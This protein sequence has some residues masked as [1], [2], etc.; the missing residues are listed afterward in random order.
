[1]PQLDKFIFFNQYL[2][3]TIF[4]IIL[5]CL[6][7]FIIL[8]LVF[9]ILKIRKKKLVLLQTSLNFFE[10]ANNNFKSSIISF[11][12]SNIL[13]YFKIQIDLLNNFYLVQFLSK[14][15]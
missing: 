9:K 6:F 5:Y 13:N 11:Y 12:N 15:Y 14:K 7:L 4:F 3:F 10:V 2:W 1:M 8:P